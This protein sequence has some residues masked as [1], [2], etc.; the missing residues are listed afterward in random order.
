M[1]LETILTC[2][3]CSFL[4]SASSP[5]LAT[6]RPVE[7]VVGGG[8]VNTPTV[9]WFKMGQTSLRFLGIMHGFR[10][11]TEPGTREGGFTLGKGYY[12]SVTNLHGWA[13]GDPFYVNYVGHPMMGAA[14]NRVFTQNDPRYNTAEFGK[15]REYWKSRLRGAAF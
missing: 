3:L 8:G 11:L 15:S 13:D 2:T 10:L 14:A 12:Q 9:E 5:E 1:V 7:P 6:I 4:S